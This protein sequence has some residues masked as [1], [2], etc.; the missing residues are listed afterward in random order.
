MPS[1]KICPWL[2]AAC[3]E[4]RC[5]AWDEDLDPPGCLVLNESSAVTEMFETLDEILD[6]LKEA[7]KLMNAYKA[8]GNATDGLKLPDPPETD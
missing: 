2:R 4:E 3:V 8:L 5:H 6:I 7:K 1:D